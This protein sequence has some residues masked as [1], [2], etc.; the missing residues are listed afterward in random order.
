MR[1]ETAGD[2]RRVLDADEPAKAE[3]RLREVV[4]CYKKT[5]WQ[6]AAWLDEHVHEPL[7]VLRIPAAHRRRLRTTNG[8]ERLN[9]EIRSRT[10]IATLFPKEASLLRVAR[11]RRPFVD[12]RRLANRKC[13]PEDGSQMSHL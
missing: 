2:I 10:P 9:K 12:Q 8:L 5:A 13:L 7:A 11:L 6:F 4:T 1:L 3:R